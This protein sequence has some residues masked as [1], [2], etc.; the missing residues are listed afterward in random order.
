M[1]RGLERLTEPARGFRAGLVAE[2]G[3]CR[4]VR[5]D[6]LDMSCQFHDVM[7]TSLMTSVKYKMTSQ[8]CLGDGGSHGRWGR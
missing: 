1:Q 6:R 3:G 8:R 2:R 5:L 7:M 4:Q